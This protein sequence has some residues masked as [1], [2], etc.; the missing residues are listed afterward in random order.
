MRYKLLLAALFFLCIQMFPLAAEDHIQLHVI[1]NYTFSIDGKSWEWIVRKE[2]IPPDEDPTYA[3]RDDMIRALDRKKRTLFNKRIFTSVEYTYQIVHE[4]ADTL[5]Y[6]VDFQIEDSFTF[7]P[8]P[9]AKYDSNYGFR[10][11]VKLFDTNLFGSF[12]DMYAFVNATQVD[13]RWDHFH[14]Y[15]ELHLD[16]IPFYQSNLHFYGELDI[17]N[18]AWNF[19]EG[20]FIAD[21]SWND[22]SLLNNSFNFNFRLSMDQQDDALLSWGDGS[23]RVQSSISRLTLYNQPFSLLNRVTLSQTEDDGRWTWGQPNIILYNRLRWLRL[24]LF[25]HS[26]TFDFISDIRFR[27]STWQ[28]TRRRLTF[29]INTRFNLPLSITDNVTLSTTFDV[30][31]MLLPVADSFT[32]SMVHTFSRGSIN[33]NNNFREG[34]RTSVRVHSQY[35]FDS[36]YDFQDRFAYD[37]RAEHISHLLFFNL[38]N[39]STRIQGFYAYRPRENWPSYMLS[40]SVT[41]AEQI[42]GRLIKNFDQYQGQAGVIINNNFTLKLIKVRRVAEFFVTPFIDLAIFSDV[43]STSKL[44]EENT[45]LVTGGM[46]AHII[47]DRYRSYPFRFSLGVN[48]DDVRS[49]LNNEIPFS[50]IEREITMSMD[51]YF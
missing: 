15:G 47:F 48:L 29:G 37:I 4:T 13:N 21:L 2:I 24:S 35:S 5:H 11:G 32:T 19:S 30:N 8:F 14:H 3:S 41:R 26:Y 43:H 23:F 25:D 17:M 22:I 46:E 31:G 9:Y 27:T 45:F 1:D 38:I 49:Y 39:I 18:E 50:G 42:R 12:T 44:K 36:S 7:L 28:V 6:D 16:D 33:W 20:A 40:S 10:M 34:S 51:L